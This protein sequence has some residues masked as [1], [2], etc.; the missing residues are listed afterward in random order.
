MI[1][2]NF[3]PSTAINQLEMWQAE[4]FDPATID[5]ELGWAAGLGMNV[6]RVYLHDLLWEHD[7]AGFCRRIDQYLA[8]A[9]RHRIGTLFVLFDDCWN[10]DFSLGPQPAPRPFVHNSGWVQSPG[11]AIVNDRSNWARLEKYVK[12]V[13]GRYGGDSRVLLWDL[14]NEPGNGES[15]GEVSGNKQGVGSLPLVEAAFA[16]ARDVENVTQPLTVGYWH[17]GPDFAQI[18][19]FLLAHSDVISF[20]CY[21]PPQVL[22]DRIRHLKQEGRPLL[23]TEYM[24]RGLG[25]T[26][27]HCLPTLAKNRIAAIHWGLVAGKTQTI[28]PWGWS[29]EKGEPEF[30]HH[31][32]FTTDGHLLYPD[33]EQ[34]IR[35][36][37][38]I[39]IA[40]APAKPRK[41]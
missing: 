21:S 31:D 20:H 11:R 17:A 29:A 33:E 26:F 10:A 28:Y 35:N 6:M 12:G 30:W 22:A 14:Y 16:W 4:T 41:N 27:S 13:L 25:S 7:A 37:I 24:V 5:R 39:S 3:V 40:N 38:S 18:N 9:D 15:A 19:A 2:A 32:V 36:S 1:G 34:A 23:C 8:I